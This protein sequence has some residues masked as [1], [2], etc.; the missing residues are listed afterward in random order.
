MCCVLP[1]LECVLAS[2]LSTRGNV[3]YVTTTDFLSQHQ[4]TI[5]E[6]ILITTLTTERCGD[7]WLPACLPACGGCLAYMHAYIIVII[8]QE[9]HTVRTGVLL[10]SV[11]RTPVRT[12]VCVQKG[13]RA[14]A[15]RPAATGPAAVSILVE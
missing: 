1:V 14:A 12:Y 8:N 6:L 11:G 2:T 10:A 5:N 13:G 9:I 7:G 4:T 15:G 3:M